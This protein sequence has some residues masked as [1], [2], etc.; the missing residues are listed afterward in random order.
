MKFVDYQTRIKFDVW[1]DFKVYVV[2]TEDLAKSRIKR[3][4]TAG[5]ASDSDTGA[6]YTR[7]AGGYGHLFFK[8]DASAEVIA[9][10]CFHALWHMFNWAGV[11]EWDNETAAYHIGYLVGKVSLFQAKVLGIKSSNK[12]RS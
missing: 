8:T 10:E 9:H 7:G 4:E 2:F 12:K 1:S 11:Q 5:V 6:L 3:Y